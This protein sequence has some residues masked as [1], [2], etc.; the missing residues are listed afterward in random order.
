MSPVCRSNFRIWRGRDVDVV[1]AG[2]VVVVGRAE[3]S[4]AVGEHLEDAF[5]EDEAALLGAGAEDLE[6]ELLFAHPGGAG[7]FE[8]LGDARQLGDA[9]LL[10]V[11][12]LD[13]GWRF[14]R[15]GGAAGC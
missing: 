6:D 7:H 9:H 8:L 10:E 1:G 13:D 12:Q 5:R 4:E 2:Q 14:G 3:E 15:G 11:T